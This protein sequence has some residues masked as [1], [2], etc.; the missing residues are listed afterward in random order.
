MWQAGFDPG[1]RDM[2]KAP[3]SP[4]ME[5]QEL[6]KGSWYVLVVW[7]EGVTQHV[8]GF[9]SESEAQ[10]WIDNESREW[11]INHPKSRP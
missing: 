5:P 4:F 8:D 7:S 9:R 10:T 2:E 11:L 6:K 1:N 3:P